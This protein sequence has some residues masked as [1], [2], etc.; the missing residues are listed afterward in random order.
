MIV[1][2]LI[3]KGLEESC[4]DA[5]VR[6]LIHYVDLHEAIRTVVKVVIDSTPYEKYFVLKID[7]S[8]MRAD[9]LEVV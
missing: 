4:V 9:V 3:K 6:S 2:Q 8:M 1:E 7:T 5:L